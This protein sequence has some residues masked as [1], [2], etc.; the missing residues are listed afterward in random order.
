MSET[1]QNRSEQA[2]PFKLQRAREKG[3]VARGMD[4]GY[5]VS[6]AVFSGYVWISGP[7]LAGRIGEASRRALTGAP[8]LLASPNAILALTGQVLG[9]LVRPLAFFVA[10]VFVVV[11]AFE[12]VQTGFV[13]S[14]EP[15]KPDFSR[16]NPTKGFKRIF[17]IRL[18]IET[19][20]NVLKLLIYGSLVFIVIR[21]ALNVDIA[22]ITDGESLALAM[23]QS[24]L[25]LLTFF[26][27]AAVAFAALDQLIA[28]GDFRKNMRMSRREIRRESRD[29]EGDPRIK[30]RRKRLHR[31]FA[32]LSQSLRNIRGADVLITNPVH[33]AVALKYDPKTMSAPKVVAQGS[34]QFAQRLKKLGFVYGLVIIENRLLARALY[35]GCELGQSVPEQYYKPIADIYLAIRERKRQDSRA[36]ANV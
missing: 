18:L 14:S 26:V 32:K 25:R 6:L 4:L 19:G 24:A 8:E 5:L 33:Y 23:R 20:K 3:S 31:E 7:S 35:H 17:S 10:I 2:T 29:R 22:A 36:R 1:E 11:L 27:I 13:F 28:R 12:I 34:H 9:S 21:T 15:L 30:Q 16:L